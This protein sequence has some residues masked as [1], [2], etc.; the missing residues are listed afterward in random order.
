MVLQLAKK[1][2]I[3]TNGNQ[4]VANNIQANCAHLSKDPDRVTIEQRR[5]KRFQLISPDASDVLVTLDDG[6]EIKESFI[7]RIFPPTPAPGLLS[8][9]TIHAYNRFIDER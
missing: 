8:L 9:C 1:L 6:T 3:Y 4:D 5:I 7:V 2:T